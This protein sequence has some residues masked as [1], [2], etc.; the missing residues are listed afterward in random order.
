MEESN[1]QDFK[2]RMVIIVRKDL[3]GWQVTN[4]IAHIS[5]CIG[6]TLGASLRTGEVFTTGDGAQYPR[7]SQYP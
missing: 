6:N 4:T 3:P 5:A 1:V 2:K 7:N